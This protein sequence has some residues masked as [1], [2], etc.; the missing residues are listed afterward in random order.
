[1]LVSGSTGGAGILMSVGSNGELTIDYNDMSPTKVVVVA[2][3]MEVGD[4]NVWS[5]VAKGSVRVENK[6]VRFEALAESNVIH[7]HRRLQDIKETTNALSG[8]GPA[9]FDTS[10]YVCDENTLRYT[11][12]RNEFIFERRNRSDHPTAFAPLLPPPA[13]SE[14]LQGNAP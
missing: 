8:F 13:R 5:G 1:L 7:T 4:Y 14:T 3:P 9:F 12:S 10:P 2:Q 11:A 6:I